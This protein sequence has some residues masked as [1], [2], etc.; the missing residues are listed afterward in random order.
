MTVVSWLLTGKTTPA[1]HYARCLPPRNHLIDRSVPNVK[2]KDPRHLQAAA[3]SWV[4]I[5]I[6]DTTRC[7]FV[8]AWELCQHTILNEASKQSSKART[9]QCNEAFHRPFSRLWIVRLRHWTTELR[10]HSAKKEKKTRHAPNFCQYSY[11]K[12]ISYHAEV[13]STDGN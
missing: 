2:S 3:H 13:S 8:G 12:L 7:Y 6:L 4:I 1:A 10:R 9:E 5:S 11:G